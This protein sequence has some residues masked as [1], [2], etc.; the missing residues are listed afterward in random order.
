MAM[1]SHSS[2]PGN[3]VYSAAAFDDFQRQLFIE[4]RVDA[5]LGQRAR[6]RADSKVLVDKL[7]TS[8][9]QFDGVGELVVR[10][11]DLT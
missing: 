9:L 5:I 1:A 11:A 3:A 7:V 6:S 8:W 2:P 10:L 4:V